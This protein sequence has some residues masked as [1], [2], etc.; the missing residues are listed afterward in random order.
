MTSPDRAV[1]TVDIDQLYALARRLGFEAA[2]LIEEGRARAILDID[3]KSHP[4]D[5]VTA[6]D[7]ACEQLLRERLAEL[8]PEDGVHGEEND[9]QEGTSGVRWI[10]DPIDGTVNYLYGLAGYAVS[11]AVEVAGTLEIGVVTQPTTGEQFHACRGRGAFCD[12]RPLHAAAPEN[13]GV[14][15]VATGFGYL[16]E[17]RAAQGTVAAALLPRV[18]D[19]RRLGSASLDLCNVAAGRVDGYY[20]WGTH[21]WDWAAGAVICRE[22]GAAVQLPEHDEG[23]VVAAAPSIAAELGDTLRSLIEP[24]WGVPR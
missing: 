14:S 24:S 16:P 19:L 3:T 2:S 20:E 17:R 11:I 18:R 22:A 10:I 21:I 15:L 9:E 5:V 13:L 7:R 1:T 8:R 6:M 23:L 12:E 4:T